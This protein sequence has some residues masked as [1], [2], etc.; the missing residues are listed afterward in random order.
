MI[1]TEFGDLTRIYQGNR[2]NFCDFSQFLLACGEQLHPCYHENV[3]EVETLKFLITMYWLSEYDQPNPRWSS[4]AGRVAL[5]SVLELAEY[6]KGD[7]CRYFEID[8]VEKIE[9]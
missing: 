2:I 8:D 5:E 6:E 9:L 1:D 3:I 7:V 4:V